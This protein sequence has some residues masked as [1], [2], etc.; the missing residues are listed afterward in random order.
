MSKLNLIKSVVLI[1]FILLLKTTIS[2]NSK[3]SEEILRD[4][5]AGAL[6]MFE[7]VA[8]SCIVDSSVNK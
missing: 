3:T 2:E 5:S 8:D 4:A 6:I 7:E 1:I